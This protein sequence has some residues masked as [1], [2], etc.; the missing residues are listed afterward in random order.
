MS[1]RSP[2]AF[3]RLSRLEGERRGR[4]TL[5]ESNRE[6]AVRRDVAV[7]D[8]V[9]LLDLVPAARPE[10]GYDARGSGFRYRIAGCAS[11]DSLVAAGAF[12]SGRWDRGLLVSMS[13]E[14]EPLAIDE[15]SFEA[16]RA[17]RSVARLRAS[18]RRRW[19]GG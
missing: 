4:T 11:A 8:A 2:R 18:G 6:A 1:I 7:H 14:L 9:R 12:R 5:G 3:R 10:S 16:A 13:A 19:G 15:L 17:T